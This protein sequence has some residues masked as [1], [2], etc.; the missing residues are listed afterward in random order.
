MHNSPLVTLTPYIRRALWA[1]PAAAN[2]LLIGKRRL[3]RVSWL[4]DVTVLRGQRD[5]GPGG[6]DTGDMGVRA[7]LDGVCEALMAFAWTVKGWKG[8][9][10]IFQKHVPESSIRAPTT[11]SSCSTLPY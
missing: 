1:G 8:G 4:G 11:R 5:V 3:G 10:D 9:L 6:G 7:F 2:R